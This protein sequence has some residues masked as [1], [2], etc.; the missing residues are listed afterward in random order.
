MKFYLSILSLFLFFALHAQNTL[1]FST[2]DIKFDK[3]KFD[4][5]TEELNK[6]NDYLNNLLLNYDITRIKLVGHTDSD[7]DSIY[8]LNLSKKRVLE[9]K[10]FVI[11]QFGLN[12][13]MILFDY[14]G[15]EKPKVNNTN[16]DSMSKNRRVEMVLAYKFKENKENKIVVEETKPILCV[17]NCKDTTLYFGTLEV[18]FNTC[19]SLLG[20]VT[21]E[22]FS[23]K[24]ENAEVNTITNDGAALVSCG[25]FC[26]G[27][28]KSCD[29]KKIVESLNKN[30]IIVRIPFT[31]CN[32]IP[33]ADLYLSDTP[34]NWG[35]DKTKSSMKV[36]SI[37]EKK[38]YEF[39][40]YSFNCFNCDVKTCWADIKVKSSK[41]IEVLEMFLWNGCPVNKVFFT[42]EK[43]NYENALVYSNEESQSFMNLY[44][45]LIYKNENIIINNSWCSLVGKIGIK[46]RIEGI[47]P[48]CVKKKFLF[49]T[50]W[51][52]G[53]KRKLNLK[54]LLEKDT[55]LNILNF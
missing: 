24:I 34:S 38:Y 52:K 17:E 35:L 12:E 19:D 10:N 25:M 8:N 45:K 53:C 48:D 30:G 39:K 41:K 20:C 18:I 51:E 43:N 23:N 50:I 21:V 4:I 44:A 1:Q 40:I 9:V 32:E 11:S 37:E 15:E 27:F 36:I 3:D 7:A 55:N 13:E 46:T 28:N 14:K 26:L 5:K 31:E 47:K 6:L 29:E 33:G 42:E 16:E 22:D 2:Y 49:F 54:K